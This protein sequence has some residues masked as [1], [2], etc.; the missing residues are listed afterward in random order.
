MRMVNG[1][2]KGV[3]HVAVVGAGLTG[4]STAL[5]L[6][7]SNF[8]IDLYEQKAGPLFGAS[9]ANEG[10]IHLG[11]VY[12]MDQSLKTARTMLRGAASFRPVLERWVSS[13]VFEKDISAPF[14]YAV[15]HSTMLNADLIRAHVLQ[16]SQQA[17]Q[18]GAQVMRAHDASIREFRSSELE[19]LFNPEHISTAFETDVSYP[20]KFGH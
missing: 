10:K 2:T 6:A 15:P 5:I 9:G 20:P 3:T 11:Y 17:Q 8:Q 19:S 12:A 7:E 16:V 18:F 1:K 14:I 13:T 4:V